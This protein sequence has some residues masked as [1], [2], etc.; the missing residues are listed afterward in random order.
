MTDFVDPLEE[1]LVQE[2]GFPVDTEDEGLDPDVNDDLIDSAEADRRA[3]D[4]DD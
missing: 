2:H 3:A 1:P 4:G